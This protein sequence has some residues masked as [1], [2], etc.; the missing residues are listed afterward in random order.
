MIAATQMA[1]PAFHAHDD[2]FLFQIEH[3][4]EPPSDTA[5]SFKERIIRRIRNGR[6][7][8]I[9]S[10]APPVNTFWHT[11]FLR[12]FNLCWPLGR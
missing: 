2:D 11:T 3:P 9:V 6:T 8:Y 10:Q 12:V 4:V 1:M 5:D 7:R